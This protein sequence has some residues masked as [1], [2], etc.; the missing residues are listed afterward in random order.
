MPRRTTPPPANTGRTRRPPATTGRGRPRA[1]TYGALRRSFPFLTGE[2]TSRGGRW[3]HGFTLRVTSRCNQRCPFCQA[4][5]P[6]SEPE[7]TLADL[8]RAADRIAA[9]FP[10]SAVVL[11]GGEPGL[12]PDLPELLA[13]LLRRRGLRLVE[14]QTNAVPLGAR[15]A[16]PVLPVSDRLRY[17]VGLH[18]LHPAVYDICTATR[19][20]LPAA[21]TGIRR[22]LAAGAAVELNCVVS[23][24]NL[25]HLPRMPA[26]LAARLGP[27]PP[28]LHFSVMG[29]PEQR[30]VGDLLVRFGE[31]LA[32]VD[33]ARR[34]AAPLGV[35]VR[36]AASASH[37]VVPACLLARRQEPPGAA[38]ADY[39]HEGQTPD[40]DRWWVRGHAC[41]ACIGRARCHGLPRSYAERFGFDELEPLGRED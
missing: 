22:L 8:L 34:R 21:L 19:G 18:A 24:F 10:G 33:E 2:R 38:A 27:R 15:S 29:I 4:V 14:L 6:P 28:P 35:E 7:P 11:T 1:T 30:E 26:L 32:A 23:R 31:L 13:Q 39:H 3:L 25:S 12:R 5:G 20:Q 37:T 36:L 9:D 17:L 40:R 41:R 16:P